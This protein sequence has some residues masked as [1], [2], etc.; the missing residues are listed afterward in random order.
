MPTRVEA[1]RIV[2]MDAPAL[3]TQQEFMDRW[4][5]A[6]LGAVLDLVF[7]LEVVNSPTGT[8]ARKWLTRFRAARGI[9]P[10]DPRTAGGFEA[11]C[12]MAASAGL[13]TTAAVDAG[14][15]VVLAPLA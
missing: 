10:A 6:G 5:A 8:A 9:D 4:E 3:L 15:P 7:T 12:A 13:V 1:G 2:V 11:L 14:R